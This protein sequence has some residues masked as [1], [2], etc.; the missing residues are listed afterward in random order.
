MMSFECCALR[1]R[2]IKFDF[3]KIYD[4]VRS[5]SGSTFGR[6]YFDAPHDRDLSGFLFAFGLDLSRSP[7]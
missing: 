5:S 4:E 1:H 7:R 2:S 3:V 6:V